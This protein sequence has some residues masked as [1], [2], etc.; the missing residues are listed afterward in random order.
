MLS[1][2]IFKRQRLSLWRRFLRVGVQKTNL[3]CRNG[4]SVT[5]GPSEDDKASCRT[6]ALSSLVSRL[7]GTISEYPVETISTV[8]GME[9]CSIY[10]TFSFF[11]YY[12]FQFSADFAFAFGLSRLFRR[13]RLPVDVLGATALK[14]CFPVLSKVQLLSILPR[15]MFKSS[16]SPRMF[17]KVT[18]TVRDTI[19]KYGLCYFLS[20]R[21][22]GVGIVFGLHQAIVAGLDVTSV[23]VYLSTEQAEVGNVLG[24]WA[25][26]VVASSILFP[27]TLV[28]TS[29]I[30]PFIGKH[31]HMWMKNTK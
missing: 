17:G 31:R 9:I 16:E 11:Q 25:G 4:L 10:G 12:D 20:S 18:A 28:A 14:K 22:V 30:A 19:N 15:K 7:N 5:A 27:M 13:V 29:Y 6:S 26:G 24:T 2:N 8:V 1:H 23:T 21:F 3:D